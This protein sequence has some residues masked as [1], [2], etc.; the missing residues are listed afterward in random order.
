[1]ESK[2]VKKEATSLVEGE[3]V[4]FSCES[5]VFALDNSSS[6]QGHKVRTLKN[7]FRQFITDRIQS[8]TAEADLTGVVLFPAKNRSY[9]QE[10]SLNASIF[11]DMQPA[12]FTMADS[13]DGI[14]PSG[15]TPMG[16][17][18]KLAGELLSNSAQGLAR[19]IL[20]TD[21]NPNGNMTRPQIIDLAKFFFEEEGF[22]LD[23]VGIKDLKYGISGAIDEEFLKELAKAGGGSYTAIKSSEDFSRYLMYVEEERRR[24]LGNGMFL[25]PGSTKE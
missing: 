1:M 5:L 12:S 11:L 18:L 4:L 22:V 17:G 20:M 19:I 16:D 6:M 14:M 2:P 23:T 15:M 24:L 3:N 13:F 21:G 10:I 7:C 25:L 9:S 8:D